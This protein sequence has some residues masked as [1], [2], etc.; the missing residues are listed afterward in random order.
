M[1]NGSYGSARQYAP[2]R[3]R[4]GDMRLSG[5]V[6]L[7][8]VMLF[9]AACTAVAQDVRFTASVD[10]NPVGVGEQLTL[11]LTLTSSGLGGGKNLQLPDMSRFRIM[12]GPN[13]SSSVEFISGAVSSSVTYSY[14]L[15]PK[16]IGK[17]TIG[18]ATIEAGGK[19]YQTSAIVLTV[20][21]T[22]QRPKQQQAPAVDASGNVGDNILLVAGVDRTH[23]LQGEQI[24]L[25]FKLYTRVRV[26]G[27]PGIKNPTMIGFWSE[28]VE[29]PN[30]P[31]ATTETLNG[32]EYSVFV[33]KRMAIFPTQSGNLEISPAEGMATVVVQAPRSNDPFDAFFRDPFGRDINV[34]LKTNALKIKVDPLPAGA[35][36]DFKGAV[37]QFAMSTEVDKKTTRTNEPVDL[38][39]KISGQGNIKLLESPAVEL[40]SDFE[41]Y[42]PKVFDSIERKGEKVFGSKTFEYLLI[43]R[44]PGLKVIKPVSFSYFDIAKHEYVRLRSPQIELNVEQGAASPVPLVAGAAR[45]D[46]RLLSQDIRFIKTDPPSLQQ[47][48]KEPYASGL[49]VILVALPVVGLAGAVVF[50]RQ[51]EEAMSDEAGYRNRRAVKV[52]QKG[53]KQAEYLLHEKSGA[54]GMPTANQRIRFYS[55]ISRALWKYLGDKL[56]IPQ[57]NFSVEAAV[58]ELKNRSVDPGLAHALR[59]LLESCDMARF[60]P[61]SLEIPAMQKAYDEAKRLIID[62]ERGLK[63]R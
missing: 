7:F 3:T 5:M 22:A 49:F 63:P 19:K 58:A 18:V 29:V 24:N 60:A 13:Q 1:C 50:A 56:N 6:R 55:E 10:R 39:V 54:K 57:A 8:L 41:Q 43:P 40:P 27:W 35:P 32:K 44:N 25:V 59:R 52:A 30:N 53:L 9:A 20:E 17:T 14:V 2:K 51:R 47:R 31:E 36:D 23:V 42:T 28:D 61:T 46:V 33:V 48:G 38:K 62:L 4:T 34:P 16:E 11:S 26:A 15:Q 45:E 12:S 21:K 37:G